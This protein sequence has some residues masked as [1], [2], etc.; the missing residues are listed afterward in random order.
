MHGGWWEPG[1]LIFNLLL[2]WFVYFERRRDSTSWGEAEREREG[3][4]FPS[5]LRTAHA[6]PDA[7]LELAKPRDR[8]LSQ[9]QEPDA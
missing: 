3:E 5:R 6:E 2:S 8:D 1:V 9:N 4:R 7:G